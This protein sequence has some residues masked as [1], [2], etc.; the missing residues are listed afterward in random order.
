MDRMNAMYS[1]L[2]VTAAILL[3][4]AAAGCAG[5]GR[6]PGLPEPSALGSGFSSYQAGSG[7]AAGDAT[8]DIEHVE[9][10]TLGD[11]LSRSLMR[12]PELRAYSWKVRAAGARALQASLW[13]NPELGV[14]FD[15]LGG[16]G[17][18][19]GFEGSEVKFLLS[20]RFELGG[21]R[22]K[23]AEAASLEG[24][25]AA[26]GYEAK[27]LD[28][29]TG[30]VRKFAEVLA[31]QEYV[32]LTGEL[33]AVAEEMAG[34]VAGRVRAGRDAPLEKTRAQIVLSNMNIRHNAAKRELELA[35][36]RLSAM[37]AGRE[38]RFETASG[39]L[40]DLAPVP[41]VEDLLPLLEDNPE[42]VRAGLEYDRRKALL[43]LENALPVPDIT[44]SGGMKRFNGRDIDL[45]VLGVA[46][47]IPIFDRNQGGR[48]AAAGEL[49]RSR[50]ELEAVR[51]R[52]RLKFE[53]ARSILSRTY[54]EAVE[55]RENLL[56]G[57]EKVYEASRKSY[58]RGKTDYLNV[59][60]AQRTMFEIRKRYIDV[61]AE[62]HS[63]RSDLERITGKPIGKDIIIRDGGRR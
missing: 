59:L 53:E 12:N 33:L 7:Q 22:R 43:N 63:A 2:K 46:I 1:Q 10:L 34:S 44:V 36:K 45:W 62:Y 28:V 21:Q 5:S 42:I 35:R 32:E 47:P 39:N 54:I 16:R 41:P 52:V 38:C 51:M 9:V 27:R 11:A 49:E 17:E 37:W 14:E 57:A 61:L 26:W 40:E 58:R 55:L 19:S 60:D 50:E 56:A 20:H 8:G 6:Q 29:Y 23:R 30:V 24:E 13:S 18:L 3:L 15:E 48:I 4:L 31:A 25:S